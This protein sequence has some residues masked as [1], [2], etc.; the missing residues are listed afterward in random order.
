MDDKF[1]YENRPPVR[2]GF[3]ENL[4]AR[5]SKSAYST[6]KA[7]NLSWAFKFLLAGIVII[8]TLAFSG[9][10]RA[11]VLY[12]LRQIAGL[13][14]QEID[15]IPAGENE[16]T[17]P[18]DVS[19]ALDRIRKDIPYE[20]S[21][22]TYVPDRFVFD[23]HVEVVDQSVFLSWTNEDKDQILML[24]DVDHG[25]QYLM[26]KNAPQ[27]IPVNGQPAMVFQGGYDRENNWDPAQ[28]TINL[29]QRKENLVYWLIYMEHPGGTLESAAV[30]DE[31]IQMLASLSPEK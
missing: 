26:G 9:P 2:E 3:G 13:N 16:V 30:Q 6:K 8:T 24:V 1:L 31:L 20:L 10:V 12:W 23:D 17:I 15:T 25:Q 22:P 7:F 27:E 29:I 21:L 11:D 28:Q 19:G 4:Y 5:L 18:P 14:V